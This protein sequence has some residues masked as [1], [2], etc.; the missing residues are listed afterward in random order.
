[1]FKDLRESSAFYSGDAAADTIKDEVAALLPF[2][3]S[4]LMPK[5]SALLTLLVKLTELLGAGTT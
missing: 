1:M 2:K 5:V 4:M 3:V